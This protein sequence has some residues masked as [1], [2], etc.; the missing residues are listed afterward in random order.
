M[1][2]ATFGRRPPLRR[3][4]TP[5]MYPDSPD[6]LPS[7]LRRTTCRSAPGA[8]AA[9]PARRPPDRRPPSPSSRSSRS[10]PSRDTRSARTAAGR[11][12]TPRSPSV[13]DARE[14]G[15]VRR[16]ASTWDRLGCGERGPAD[17][18][19]VADD[20]D[21]VVV[22]LNTTV[23]GGGQAA[24]TGIVISSDGKVLTNNHVISGATAITVEFAA[25][26]ATRPG[27]GARLQRRS[28]TSR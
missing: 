28:T 1:G 4:G 23:E 5:T 19:E 21:D 20:V 25:T 10:R 18:G 9:S 2:A 3:E 7:R 24:G 27:Q 26:G 11:R 14:H 22:N 12:A 16:R 6:A 15:P 8:G 17:L 13:P